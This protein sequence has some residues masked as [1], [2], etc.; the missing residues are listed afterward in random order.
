MPPVSLL[1]LLLVPVS[2]ALRVLL[3]ADSIWVFLSAAAAVAALAE[4]V[5]RATDQ[6]AERA[7]SAIGGLLNVSFG[8][9]AELILAILVLAGGHAAVVQA[10]VTGSIIGTSLLGLGLAA[11]AGG[12]NHPRQ[13]LNKET[14]GLLSTMLLLVTIALLVP[15]IFDLTEHQGM[16]PRGAAIADEHLSLAVSVV[17]LILYGANLVYTM[18]THR[19]MFASDEHE[20][21]AQAAWPLSRSLAVLVAGTVAIAGEA[22]LVSDALESTARVLHLSPAFIGVIL[23]ALVGTAADLFSAV[24]FAR[25]NRMTMVFNICIGSAIQVA[26]VVAPILVLASWAMGRPMNLVFGNPLDLM[27]V[28]GAAFVIRAIAADGETTW[29]EGLLL[30][31]V[32]A[33]LGAAFFFVAPM[34]T[35]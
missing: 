30:V 28:G 23:L 17:L 31:G 2:V 7:G 21:D 26:L 24:V 15:A 13:Q 33:L 35:G 6:I 29:F 20:G 4:W 16:G 5:R 11:M 14:A 10:Q 9:I 22:E 25:Q 8:S 34:P 3:G 27:A 19:D 32:Y 1:L 18:V 12:M